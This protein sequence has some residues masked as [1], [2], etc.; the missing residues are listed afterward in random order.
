MCKTP[1]EA[2]RDNKKR[3]NMNKEKIEEKLKS[4]GLTPAYP[5]SWMQRTWEYLISKVQ[6]NKQED[7]KVIKVYVFS[8]MTKEES[9]KFWKSPDIVKRNASSKKPLMTKKQYRD[10][11]KNTAKVM[12]N[13]F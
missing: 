2:E 12:K 3:E 5:K 6:R 4:E 1:E 13:E 9:E 10:A 7:K 8:T 11:C